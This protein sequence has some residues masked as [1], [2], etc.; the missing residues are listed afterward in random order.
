LNCKFIHYGNKGFTF[1]FDAILALIIVSGIIIASGLFF[2][3]EKAES[4]LSQ[5]L[6]GVF[7]SMEETGFLIIQV[8]S[9][10]SASAENIYNK[11]TGFFPEY[12]DFNISIK[13]YDLNSVKCRNLQ[14]FNDCFGSDFNEFTFG[15]AVPTNKTIF[16]GK[17]LIVKKQPP[18]ECDTNILLF[19]GTEK[20]F[21]FDPNILFF[22]G[23]LDMN[24]V[25][26][27]NTV[28]ADEIECDQNIT[29]NLS[30]SFPP[31]FRRP[32]DIMLVVDKSGSM[33]WGGREDTYRAFGVDVDGDYAYIADYSY[34]IR[35][36]DVNP[37]LEPNELDRYD[38]YYA[39]DV[40]VDGSYAYLA[41]YTSGI[42]SIN[43]SNP[44]NMFQAD[45]VDLSGDYSYGVVKSGNYVF[46]GKWLKRS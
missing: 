30:A 40:F 33:S 36:F 10:V 19:S 22:D 46:C 3:E 21:I 17:K 34:G 1:S 39:Y 27:V 32:V 4:S 38:T 45:R 8:D 25:F 28:P 24:F 6:D 9:N 2:T 42:R 29:V 31:G 13:Q 11:L 41:D 15:S 14:T 12:M 23:A 20:N 44:N 43:I 16:Y 26:D 37:P 7:N 18:G 35:S 5:E